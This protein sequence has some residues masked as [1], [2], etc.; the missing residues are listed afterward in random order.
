MTMPTPLHSPTATDAPWWRH[1]VIYQVYPRSWSDADGD[2][3]GDLRG[4]T[5]R[6]EYLAD[7]GVDALW[8]SPFYRSPMADAGY[9]VADY[10]DID[11]LFGTMDDY[12]ALA[13]KAADLGLRII[14]DLVPNHSSVEH[15][16]FRAALADGP[17]SEARARYIFRDGTGPGGS[18]PPNNWT[19]VFGGRAWTRVTEPDGTPGQWYLHLF[20]TGQPDFDWTNPQ[21]HAEFE[22]ILRFWLE[23]GVAGFRV[24]VAHG[25]IKRAGLPPWDGPAETRDITGPTNAAPFWDQDE[26]HDIYRRWR[27]LID[28]YSTPGHERIMCAE[29]WV[30]PPERAALYVRPDEFHQSFN[31]DYLYTPFEPAALRDV[32]AGSL[33]LADGYGAPT[34]WVLSNH[35]VVRHATR[36]GYAT[37]GRGA[38]GIGPQDPQ[39]DAALGLRRAR[40]ATTLMLALPGSAYVYQGEELGLPEHTT[41]PSEFRQDPTFHRTHG[42]VIGRDGCRVPLPWVKDAPAYGFGPGGS[43]LP[44]PASYADLAVDQQTGVKGS[45]LELYRTLLRLRREHSLGTGGLAWADGFGDEVVALVNTGGEGGAVT[46]V[47]NLGAEPVALPAGARVL[48]SSGALTGDGAVPTDTSVWFTVGAA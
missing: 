31:F 10:R 29:A 23:R 40:A 11:P 45:T 44:Q 19:S 48:V 47:T 16:W 35:D 36:Y 7:L 4:I 20:D 22:S 18:E 43:W 34:T 33:A 30:T 17:G 32:I 15:V 12:D 27:A 14:V 46:V 42:A 41:M 3:I 13:A 37:T 38:L 5:D 28:E 2:G 6:L 39:P 26:I 21:V 8:F 25:L 24:D 9:D 1:A